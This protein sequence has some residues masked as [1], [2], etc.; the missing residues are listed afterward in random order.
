V[1]Y[2]PRT[3]GWPER[4]WRT[5][6]A[7][8]VARGNVP[9][10]YPY[11][12]FGEHVTAGAVNSVVIRETGMPD[13]LTVPSGI[14]LT[15]V[16]TS[17]SDIGNLH[18]RYLD[19]DLL[20]RTEVVTL[21]GTA[22]VNTVADDIRAINNAYYVGG[23]GVVGTVTG[24]SGGI[25]HLHMPP[26]DVQYNTSMQRVPANKRLMITGMYAGATSGTA[27]AGA[28]VKLETSFINGDSF[29]DL[30][31]LHPVAAIGLQD[32][33]Q[34]LSGF[35][36]FPIKPGEWVGFTASTDKAAKIVAGILGWM[37]DV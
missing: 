14:R 28:T 20:E 19:G 18:I 34:S 35:G 33:S 25:M 36:T 11:T 15:L 8:D 3:S 13:F 9:G 5:N 7:M 10:S 4:L 27:A 30:G 16:S 37:E 6:N 2:T 32:N 1:T 23:P 24:V 17:A 31:Y 22:S 12:T 29:A 26:G 21:T